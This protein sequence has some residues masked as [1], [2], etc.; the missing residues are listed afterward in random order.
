MGIPGDWKEFQR[1]FFQSHRVEMIGVK[2]E[3]G[4]KHNTSHREY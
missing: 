3:S 4:K 1:S 2:T